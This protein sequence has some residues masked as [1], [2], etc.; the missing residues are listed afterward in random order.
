MHP[1]HL[2]AGSLLLAAGCTWLRP[3]RS[4]MGFA[5]HAR[6][7]PARARGVVVLLPGFGD[8]PDGFEDHGFLRV[9]QQ[10]APDTTSLRRTRTLA[11]TRR[12]MAEARKV[13]IL[14]GS[15]RRSGNS[16]TLAGAV[17]RGAQA[18]GAEVRLRFVDDFI[19]S[20][21]R[22]CRTCRGPDGECRIADDF[23]RLMF[24]DFLPAQAV[25]F[26]S[27]VYWYGLSAQIKAFF[28]RTFCY[29]AAS[30]AGSAQVI[31]GMSRKRIG[32]ALASEET[33][34]GAT[35]GIIHQI[36]EFARYTHSDFVGLV[37]GVGNSR[38]EVTSD[39]A[40]PLRAAE[41]LG[42]EIFDR[43]YSDFRLDTSRSGRVWPAGG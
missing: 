18:A 6:L 37:R 8:G 43:R 41:Q 1:R 23:R 25:V 35:L 26:C 13:L 32:L 15:P 39:P 30:Y 28:D 20:F 36:Q 24:D 5:A 16:A 38:G 12:K 40:D 42:R 34:P 14:V 27:P 21:L 3:A 29:Y 17:E 4:P 2:L 19:T 22:D 31:E 7:G 10:H 33:Y 9:L 11:T